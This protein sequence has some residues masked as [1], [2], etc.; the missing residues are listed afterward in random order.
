MKKNVRLQLL[1][2]SIGT[3]L[4]SEFQ[5]TQWGIFQTTI[6]L[7]TCV[8]KIQNLCWNSSSKCL[9]LKIF[10]LYQR[11]PY[12]SKLIVKTV[13]KGQFSTHFQTNIVS[14]ITSHKLFFFPKSLILWGLFSRCRYNILKPKMWKKR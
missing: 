5:V 7:M 1:H 6:T 12:R 8:E 10:R 9:I 13:T 11:I 3:L 4:E 14:W 2:P